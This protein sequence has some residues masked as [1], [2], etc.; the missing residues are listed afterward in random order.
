MKKS[1]L[2]TLALGLAGVS[3]LKAVDVYITGSTAFRA[4]VYT[5]CTNLFASAPSIYYGDANHGGAGSGFGPKTGAW[6][7]SGTASSAITKLAPGTLLTIHAL[8]TGSIQGIASVENNQILTFPNADGTVNNNCATYANAAPTIGFSD[9][10]SSA[11]PF[12]SANYSNVKEESVAV[13]PF[14]ICK[15]ASSSTAMN[16]INNVTSDQFLYGIQQGRIPLSAWSANTADTNNFI[17][18]LERTLDSGT[19]R[20][21]TQEHNYTYNDTV[22][23]YIYDATANN[24]FSPTVLSNTAAGSAPYG[25]VSSGGAGL[26][27]A[28]LN[29]GYGYVGGGDIKTALAIGNTANLSISCLSI[30]DA[31]GI[32]SGSANNWSQ[33]ISFNGLWPT[34][35]GTGIHGNTGTN[36]FSP[37]S[38]GFYPLWGEEVLIHLINPQ[39]ITGQNMTQTQ[40]GDN[41]TPGSFMG[42]FNAQTIFNGG[43]PAVGSIE[44]EI[45]K[46]KTGSPGATAIRLSEMVN[47]RG[48]VGGTITPPFN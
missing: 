40:L 24:F 21:F 15:S 48:A 23:V 8:F 45:E 44:N 43:S 20:V 16:S 25:V 19:R 30:A 41:K 31:Q 12:P 6:A 10:A 13:Q 32:L 1:L 36:D 18:V 4:N 22:G 33:V 3:N 2:L 28:N 26:N 35:A 17:Y 5:A 27:N 47:S 9:S 11:C 34:A 29:W 46:S 14:V 7:M 39:G 42:V 37:I 38:T